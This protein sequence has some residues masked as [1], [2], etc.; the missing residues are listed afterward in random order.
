MANIGIYQ[1][2]EFWW[3]WKFNIWGTMYYI[4]GATTIISSSFAALRPKSGKRVFA[5]NSDAWNV[6]AAAGAISAAIIGT[7]HPQ[8][9][10]ERFNAA[11][12]LLHEAMSSEQPNLET[13]GAAR[14]QG[15]RI[16]NQELFAK[17][18][19]RKK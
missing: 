10:A 18:I 14:D 12:I 7:F 13:L 11:W 4:L 6:L 9:K 19:D 2:L 17:Y 3:F 5:Y 16:I 15:E 1:S 8:D